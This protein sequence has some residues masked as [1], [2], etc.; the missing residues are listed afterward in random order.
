VP[1][2]HGIIVKP[3][4]SGPDRNQT[5]ASARAREAL[6]VIPAGRPGQIEDVSR[7]VFFLAGGDAGL[8]SGTTLSVNG[9]RQMH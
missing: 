3:L 2:G 8:T 7:P 6:I 4:A 9:G 1:P 5:S